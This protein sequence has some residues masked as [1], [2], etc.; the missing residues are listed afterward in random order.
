MKLKFS[1]FTRIKSSKCDL[2][3]FNKIKS[4]IKNFE[5]FFFLIA[6]RDCIRGNHAH[7]KCSQF[8]I[9]LKDTIKMEIEDGTKKKKIQLKP[10]NIVKIKPLTWVKVHLKKNQIVCVICD[11]KYSPKEYIRNYDEFKN[12]Y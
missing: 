4:Y 5:R 11:E 9:S 7:K 3:Y 8:F 1:K 10:G 6:K 2:I 12:L